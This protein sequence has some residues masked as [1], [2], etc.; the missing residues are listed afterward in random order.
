MGVLIREIAILYAAFVNGEPSPLPELPVQYADFAHW[1]RQWFQGEVLQQQLAYWKQRLADVPQLQLPTDRAR[2][3]IQTFQ[4]AVYPFQL[5][6]SLSKSL[7]AF[8]RAEG[9]TL[10]MT[11]LA[12]FQTLLSH[13][14][15][16]EDVVVGSPIANRTRSEIESLIGFFVNTLVMRSD[17]TGDPTFGQLVRRVRQVALGAFAHQDLPF[18][19]LVEE[20]HPQR[21]LSREPLFQVMFALQNAPLPKFEIPGQLTLSPFVVDNQTAKFDLTVFTWETA[22]GVVGSVQYSTD[23]FD[24]STIAWIVDQF[25]KLLQ[26]SV[27][28]PHQRLSELSHLTA[29]EWRQVLVEW[30]HAG[31][32]TESPPAVSPTVSLQAAFEPAGQEHDD[33]EEL[34]L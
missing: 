26:R 9:V 28:N 4:G 32:G 3:S 2:P 1:Q 14:T 11:L 25:R 8:S 20:L 21:D 13:I 5:S 18:E 6:P 16:Q 33:M 27:D 7:Q 19:K 31:A 29:V 24:E 10:F 34:I 17:L 22:H 23:L 12:G 30:G 15:G